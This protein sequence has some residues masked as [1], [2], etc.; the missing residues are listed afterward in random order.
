MAPKLIKETIVPAEQG[1]GIEVRA[2]QTLRVIAVDGPQVADIAFIRLDDHTETYDAV[3]SYNANAIMGVGTYYK[4]KYLY[5]RMPRANLMLEVTDDKVGQHWWI[6]GGHCSTMSAVPRRLVASSRSCHF[7]VA[8]VIKDYGMTSHQVPNTF[9]LWMWVQDRGDGDY[10]ILPSP[11]KK[12]DYIDF[13]AHMDILAAISACPADAKD[14]TVGTRINPPLN[15][16][17]NRPLKA[18]VWEL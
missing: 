15:G 5:S 13:L 3:V 11:A 18:Q 12:G 14:T 16:G 10:D 1:G 4:P 8:E 2:G 17:M 7:N 9:P 6:N